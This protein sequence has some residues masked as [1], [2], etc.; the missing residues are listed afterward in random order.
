V[1]RSIV[2]GL[3]ASDLSAR[4]LPFAQTIAEQWRGRLIL[5]HASGSGEGG[6]PVPLELELH[7]LVRK[8]AVKGITAEAVVRA[9]E[10][11]QAIVDVAA[12][13]DADLIVMASHQRH[14]LDR[15]VNGSVTEQVLSLSR[16][17]LL[18]VPAHTSNTKGPVQRI[19]IPLDGTPVGEAPL[20][21]LRER[22]T[23]RPIDVL[24]VRIVS[25]APIVVGM[26][27]AF[28]STPLTPAEMDAEVGEATRDL[29]GLA[30]S[31]T[32]DRVSARYQV[33]V[34]TESVPRVILQAARDAGAELIAVGSHA[35]SGMSRLV[36]G[37]VSEEILERSP[38]P[39]LLMRPKAETGAR[40]THPWVEVTRSRRPDQN[41]A[42]LS[43]T[44][45]SPELSLGNCRCDLDS[46]FEAQ[47]M[48]G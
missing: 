23:T 5:V 10:P 48:Q 44:S 36:L 8:L 12:E 30:E 20:D 42:S 27:P 3:D 15:W 40:R 4:A 22:A 41:P 11:A 31:I 16:T 24:L 46:R 32:D 38:I 25:D 28:I 2:I 33:I 18:V 35:K 26:A 39:V 9:A 17:P 21:F 43:I 14:G 34:A 37:S 7:E 19:L 6:T 45:V 13:R 47:L 1:S 29:A